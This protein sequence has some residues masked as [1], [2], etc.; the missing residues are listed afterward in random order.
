MLENS[1]SLRKVSRSGDKKLNYLSHE[2]SIFDVDNQVQNS[3]EVLPTSQNT[4]EKMRL[5]SVRLCGPDE[6]A[7]SHI[8][9]L[10]LSRI[11]RPLPWL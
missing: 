7:Y 5:V 8:I 1:R 4:G 2:G 3:R 11:D 9:F 6:L 10:F